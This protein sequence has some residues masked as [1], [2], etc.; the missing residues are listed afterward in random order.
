QAQKGGGI[1]Q[2]GYD[3][4]YGRDERLHLRHDRPLSDREDNISNLPYRNQIL[5]REG[6]KSIEGY[7][8]GKFT[9]DEAWLKQ[10]YLIEKKTMQEIADEL[11]VS[12]TCVRNNIYRYGIP[13][14]EQWQRY[15]DGNFCDL[16]EEQQQILLGTLLGD[17]NISLLGK[18]SKYHIL[19][20]CHSNKQLEYLKWKIFMLQEFFRAELYVRHDEHG[21]RYQINSISH[22]IFTE[23]YNIFYSG[24]RKTLN[25]KILNKISE[26]GLAVWFMDDGFLYGANKKKGWKGNLALSTSNFSRGE[27]E[28]LVQWFKEKWGINAKIYTRSDGFLELHFPSNASR[29]FKKLISPYV[30]PLFEYKLDVSRS[31]SEAKKEYWRQ[32]K[33]PTYL[34]EMFRIYNECFKVLKPHGKMIIIV[35]DFV[36]NFKVVKLHE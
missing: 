21:C 26:L 22:P 4:Q 27:H 17:A 1:A 31:R 14:L 25:R 16:E 12:R 33:Q 20:L 3:G 11:G 29:R 19:R 5:V 10:K 23:L 6:T 9:I 18:G 24:G 34:S 8:R 28:L 7:G 36:R 13:V 32:R 15:F 2:K 30:L 35:K